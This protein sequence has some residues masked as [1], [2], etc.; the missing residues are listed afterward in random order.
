[1]TQNTRS[2]SQKIT[3]HKTR[4]GKMQSDEETYGSLVEKAR[5]VCTMPTPTATVEQEDYIRNMSAVSS[6]DDTGIICALPAEQ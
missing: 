1:M 5:S 2:E 3:S 4:G 6:Y